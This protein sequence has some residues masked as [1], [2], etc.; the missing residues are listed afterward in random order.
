MTDELKK[1]L[2]EHCRQ[3]MLPEEIRALARFGLIEHGE[4]TTSE[5]IKW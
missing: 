2:L 3:W 4:K 5:I 1:H